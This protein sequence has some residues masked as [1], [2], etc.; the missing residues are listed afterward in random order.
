M[1]TT[2]QFAKLASTVTNA[3]TSYADVTGLSVYLPAN[4][5]W[6]FEAGIHYT[7]NATTTGSGWSVNGPASP[8]LLICTS[9]WSLT[10]TSNSWAQTTAYDTIAANATSASTTDNY[11]RISGII[12]N[13]STAG[14]FTVRFISEV[15][16][17]SAIVA[18]I[19]SW[20]EAR[21]L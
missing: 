21:P 11:A 3:T 1:A 20:F 2:T 9:S 14:A 13:G 6:R 16:V 17:A 4:T 19:G 18:Q 15:A 7:C 10:T 5:D 8:T 12:R